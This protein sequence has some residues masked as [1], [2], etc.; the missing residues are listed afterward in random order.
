MVVVVR[1]L[2]LECLCWLVVFDLDVVI[3]ILFVFYD[4]YVLLFKLEVVFDVKV[5]VVWFI[6]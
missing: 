6:E 5:S 1:V 2:F 3:V 4:G